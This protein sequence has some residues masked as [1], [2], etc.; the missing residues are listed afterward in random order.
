MSANME[1]KHFHAEVSFGQSL[2]GLI[3]GSANYK[4][5]RSQLDDMKRFWKEPP[6]DKVCIL[7]GLRR[8]GKTTLLLQMA[9]ELRRKDAKDGSNEFAR[10]A[11]VLCKPRMTLE[12]VREDFKALKQCGFKT[13]LF[14]EATLPR[15]F[16]QDAAFLADIYARIG[17]RIFMAGT[18][19]LKF[20]NASKRSLYDRC[21]MLHT[22]HIPYREWSRITGLHGPDSVDVYADYGGT[23]VLSGGADRMEFEPEDLREK[24]VTEYLDEAVVKNIEHTLDE[25]GSDSPLTGLQDLQKA[26]GLKDLINWAVQDDNHSF[27]LSAVNESFALQDFENMKGR[28][29]HTFELDGR[30]AAEIGAMVLD[31]KD[32]LEIRDPKERTMTPDAGL[33]TAARAFL[34]DL[35][36]ML[37]KP[38]QV[39]HETSREWVADNAANILAMPAMRRCM[40]QLLIDGLTEESRFT[41]IAL[42]LREKAASA[43][44]EQVHGRL[45]EDIAMTE[46]ADA[47]RDARFASLERLRTC[48][49]RFAGPEDGPVKRDWRSAGCLPGER[50][51]GEIDIA[52]FWRRPNP[53]CALFEVKRSR[54]IDLREHAKHLTDLEKMEAVRMRFGPPRR[55]V[56][57]YSGP[58]SL[59]HCGTGIDYVSIAEF[60][61]SMPASLEVAMRPDTNAL[62]RVLAATKARHERLKLD[63]EAKRQRSQARMERRMLWNENQQPLSVSRTDGTP[64]PGASSPDDEDGGPRP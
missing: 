55:K 32:A 1:N 36:L 51:K 30:D 24:K 39:Y 58:T 48:Q 26:G 33:C 23:F 41:H 5:A 63:E 11:Y 50:L 18:D 34:I 7:Y 56:I 13:V 31:I 29:A 2:E 10:T 62:E 38:V 57:L 52:V 61:E 44:M 3:K 60:L 42:E 15:G 35:D 8:T 43:V 14:D 22:T 25:L 16:I 59:D 45:L 47:L 37:M 9:E 49:V 28:L 17:M 64:V 6:R 46:I 19:S 20:L 12:D 54:H 27:L 40:A 53:G 4:E 21:E